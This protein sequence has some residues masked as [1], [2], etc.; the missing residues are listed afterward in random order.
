MVS[1]CSFGKWGNLIVSVCGR[2]AAQ[3]LNP[4]YCDSL[5]G[6]TVFFTPVMALTA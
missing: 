5:L 3:K 1:S 4:S 6:W 2:L